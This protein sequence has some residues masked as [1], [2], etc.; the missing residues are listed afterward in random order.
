MAEHEKVDLNKVVK[1]GNTMPIDRLPEGAMD[2]AI[3]DFLSSMPSRYDI[4]TFVREQAEFI[5]AQARFL[6]VSTG[7]M[8]VVNNTE[9]AAAMTGYSLA[10]DRYIR[11][12]TR[13]LEQVRVL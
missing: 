13:V 1:D 11:A 10:Q 12:L 9:Y 7:A 4:E 5:K 6:G 2:P 8:T 3:A